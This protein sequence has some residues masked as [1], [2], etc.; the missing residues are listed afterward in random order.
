VEVYF[1]DYRVVN[2]LQI[3]FILESRVLPVTQ[4]GQKFMTPPVPV[5]KTI[6]EAVTV[7]PNLEESLF[8]K[9]VVGAASNVK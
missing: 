6:I 5:E 7:N 4:P 8:S 3:P 9:P 1:R 2:G